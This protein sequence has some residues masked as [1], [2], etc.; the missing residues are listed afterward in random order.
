MNLIAKKL[1]YSLSF[2]A[3]KDRLAICKSQAIQA[4]V[5]TLDFILGVCSAAVALPFV[6][7]IVLSSTFFSK[8][9]WE[10]F[11]DKFLES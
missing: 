10:E 3:R 6:T 1:F 7:L 9:K 5:K 8:D 4:P 2:K 11:W